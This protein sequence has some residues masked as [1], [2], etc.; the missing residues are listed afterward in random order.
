M[1]IVLVIFLAAFV[2]VSDLGRLPAGFMDEEIAN[3]RIAET[4]RTGV[5]GVFYN[6]DSASEVGRESFFALMQAV[7]GSLFGDSLFGFRVLPFMAGL[8]SVALMYA[9]GRRLY[10]FPA[11]LLCAILFAGGLY[12]V[13]LSRLVIPQSLLMVVYVAA[14]LAMARGIHLGE[15]VRPL[16]PHTNTFAAL[17]IFA[18]LGFYTHFIG[19]FL[20]PIMAAFFIY[21]RRTGQPISRRAYGYLLFAFALTFV[22]TLPYLISTLR[23]P[24]A[25]GIGALWAY[26]PASFWMLFANLFEL[27]RSLLNFGALGVPGLLLIGGLGVLLVIGLMTAIQRWR[28][29]GYM[30]PV[31]MLAGGVVP[32]IW[33]GR[34]DYDLTIAMPGAV[35]LITVG[36]LNGIGRLQAIVQNRNVRRLVW[37]TPILSL[38]LFAALSVELFGRWSNDLDINRQYHGYLGN[39]AVYLNSADSDIP[40][41]ICTN[42]LIGTPTQPV[43]DPILMEL[44]LHSTTANLRFSVCETA[45][46]IANGGARQRVAFNF[47]RTGSTPPALGDWLARL[48]KTP[49]AI[50]GIRRA[51]IYEIAGES[52]I[53][54]AVGKLS[55]SDVTWP[56]D[57]PN[58]TE[59]I[60]LP[61]R[62]GDYL[63]FQGYTIDPARVYKPGEMVAITSYWRVDSA[64][65]ADLRL[66]THILLDPGSSPVAQ[67]DS[68]DVTATLLRPRD[69]VIQTM[70]VQVPYP[71]PDGAYYLSVGAY[72]ALTNARIPFFDSRDRVRGDR[73]FIGT[74]NVKS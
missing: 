53:A 11:G 28:S 3:L 26:R 44:M 64:Q 48:K 16:P 22:L 18:A 55:L 36:A 50:K 21:L 65:A 14:W 72:H 59:R 41:L 20:I 45:I 69:I 1:L 39:L 40:T 54:D 34:A 63:T 15:G 24:S 13:L 5:I 58:P 30:L 23:V 56:P 42:T 70:S 8:V 71:F 49:V 9:L 51:A 52:E 37:A 29:P 57:T 38:T 73:L 6:P 62:M 7:M 17:G 25:S 4:A 33:T 43:P 66:F 61:I 68:L 10:G 74:I 35:L 31:I 2:R 19:L 27:G 12:P 32:V 67:N 46:I 47:D 60:T